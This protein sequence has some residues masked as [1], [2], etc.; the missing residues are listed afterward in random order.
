MEDQNASRPLIVLPDD[1]VDDEGRF[2]Q[3]FSSKLTSIFEAKEAL[4]NVI[5]DADEVGLDILKA[6]VG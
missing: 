3:V 6:M 4:L 1:T 5:E 2:I